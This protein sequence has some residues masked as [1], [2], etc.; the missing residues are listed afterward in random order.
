[1]EPPKERKTSGA[2]S[3]VKQIV[4]F[5]LELNWFLSA[6]A[7]LL[8]FILLKKFVFDIARVNSHDM[9][10]T[11]VYGDALLIRR[12]TDDLKRG[13]V[14]QFVFPVRDTT[15]TR[16]LMMQRLFGMPGDTI[17]IRDKNVLI[18]GF[19]L[20]DTS[21]VQYNY[22]VRAKSRLDTAFRMKFNLWEGGDI[23]ERGDYS[24]SLTK[25]QAAALR[26]DT[27]TIRSVELKT[28]KK[29]N[30]DETIF[31]SSPHYRWNIDHYGPLYVPRAGDTLNLDTVCLALYETL[32][33]KYEKNTL[34]KR[35]D[36][37]FINGHY[38]KTY[39]TKKDY[40]FMLGDNRDNAS[41]SRT[42]GLLP[43]NDLRGKMLMVLRRSGK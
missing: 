25:D 19:Q 2:I 32:I 39:V 31:P 22:F 18:N 43:R 26:T 16:A 5:I 34:S 12:S 36:S 27:N 10:S 37:I 7:A 14:I 40:Y 4:A 42:W 20:T 29:D 8:L 30:W 41:D 11:Y 23:S 24:F 17:E 38:T 33:T 1:M 28:E 3:K 6:S 21:T 13:D 9:N 15:A 35:S